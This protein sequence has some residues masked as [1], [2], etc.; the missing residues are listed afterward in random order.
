MGKNKKMF[1]CYDCG[2]AVIPCKETQKVID[3]FDLYPEHLKVR[4]L[5]CKKK[6]YDAL[7]RFVEG[8]CHE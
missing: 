6:D 2:K 3:M 5:A 1:F 7:V 4:C 8:V